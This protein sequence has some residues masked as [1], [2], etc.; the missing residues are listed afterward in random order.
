MEEYLIGA[1]ALLTA[2]AA[3]SIVSATLHAKTSP[4][5]AA[6]A[7]AVAVDF[8]GGRQAELSRVLIVAPQWNRPRFEREVVSRLLARASCTLADVLAELAAATRSPEVHLF[9]RW[10]PDDV[11]LAALRRNGVGLVAH[12]LET[13]DRAALICGQDITRWSAPFRAA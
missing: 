1:G 6:G 9:A 8:E 12:P 11:T 3:A 13:I 10:T 7:A 4:G 5:I 2:G